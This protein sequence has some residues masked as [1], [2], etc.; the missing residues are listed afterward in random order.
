MTTVNDII[1][2]SLEMTGI[3]S[4]HMSLDSDDAAMG[5]RRINGILDKWNITKLND[6]AV[7]EVS[8]PLVSGEQKYTI[9]SGGDVD[10][11]RPVDVIDV[12]VQ[13][14]GS[15]NYPVTLIQF[16]QWNSIT[17]RDVSSDYPSFV[18]YNPVNPLGEINIYPE[19]TSNYTMF[20]SV[21]TGFPAYTATSDTVILPT[22][23]KE[24]LVYQLA[25]ELCSFFG[26]QIPRYVEQ[27]YNRILCRV[28]QI[29]YNVWAETAS[30]ETPSNRRSGIQNGKTYIS[31]GI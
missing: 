17:Q 29:N 18:W 21:R 23:Y 16:D 27:E 8:F 24:L 2:E 26:E 4:G 25:V 9:G 30:V 20:L 6:Y 22:G 14:T 13:D 11:T 12:Y 7:G 3:K 28:K 31:P 10:T 1:T 19:P 5:L 15:T